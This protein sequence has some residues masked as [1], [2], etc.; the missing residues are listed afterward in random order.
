MRFIVAMIALT[1]SLDAFSAG[2]TAQG[3]TGKP[4][5]LFS[6]Y[7]LTG[8][9]DG[10][11]FFHMR[12]DVDKQKMNCTLVEGAYATLM[13]THPL[14]KEIYSS[15]LSASAMDRAVY[16]RVKGGSSKCEIAYVRLY[17]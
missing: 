2:C 9:E 5:E 14:F 13:S 7:Y 15:L 8:S 6:N 3:C 10:R 1:F 17:M 11:I 4:S 12:D 16:I